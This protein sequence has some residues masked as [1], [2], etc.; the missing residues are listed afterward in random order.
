MF[1]NRYFAD[2]RFP[3]AL[4]ESRRRVAENC[5]TRFVFFDIL[6]ELRCNRIGVSSIFGCAAQIIARIL[7][8][9]GA[10]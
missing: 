5:L 2:F 4:E 7:T 8:S 9:E 6:F 3:S 10:V 1:D